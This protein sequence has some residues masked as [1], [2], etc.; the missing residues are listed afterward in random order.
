MADLVSPPDATEFLL[1]RPLYSTAVYT[2]ES[3]WTLREIISFG[4]RLDSYCPDCGR[5]SV[6]QGTA[7]PLPDNR[8]L[9]SAL[10]WGSDPEPDDLEEGLLYSAAACARNPAHR[11]LVCMLVERVGSAGEG[12]TSYRLTKIGQYP[13]LADV[14]AGDLRSYKA[15]LGE[16]RAAEL[17]RGIGL[18]AHGVGIGAFVY[19]RRLWESFVEEAHALAR[20]DAAWSESEYARARVADRI[21]MLH[22]YLPESLVS[23]SEVYGILS[24]GIH[25]LSEEECLAHFH[26]LQTG[27]EVILEEKVSALQK[28]NRAQQLKA[29]L[30]KVQSSLGK[31]NPKSPTPSGEGSQQGAAKSSSKRGGHQE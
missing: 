27:L 2:G 11:L 6:F 9:L 4:G 31:E 8:E 16:Q 12:A 14:H 30:S 5:E 23:H 18:A 13:S 24:K 25:E 19:L 26:V 22:G 17:N 21:S 10:S 1:S 29:A 7:R 20:Q 15:V 3:L 28:A